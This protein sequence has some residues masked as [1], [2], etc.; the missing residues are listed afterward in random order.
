MNNYNGLYSNFNNTLLRWN[1]IK[2]TIYPIVFVYYCVVRINTDKLSQFTLNIDRKNRI[3]VVLSMYNEGMSNKEI[4]HLLNTMGIRSDRGKEWY[5]NLV[6]SFLNKYFKRVKRQS[7]SP[8]VEILEEKWG[9]I[10]TE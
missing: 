5:P 9:W 2:N 1:N 3:D 10:N 7:A 4:S 6:W 8:K